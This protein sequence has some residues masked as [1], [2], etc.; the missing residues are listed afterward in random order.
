MELSSP[1]INTGICK[2]LRLKVKKGLQ[3]R[4]TPSRVREAVMNHLQHEIEESVFV[5]LYAGSGA[6]G[7]EAVSRGAQEVVW[8][9]R[10]KEAARILKENLDNALMRFEKQSFVKPVTRVHVND[11]VKVL[12]RLPQAD[13]VWLDAPWD[14]THEQF[15]L[16]EEKLL[17]L[18]TP[19]GLLIVEK[20]KST[21]S[22][23]ISWNLE[24]NRCYGEAEVLIWR[25]P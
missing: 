16:I 15:A 24:W 8:V 5:D 7:F 20:R 22:L 19:G 17:N 10:D 2:G 23:T 3:T 9:E 25:K 21:A 1:R 6:M 13:I 4:P 18:V 11:V 12:D 14:D